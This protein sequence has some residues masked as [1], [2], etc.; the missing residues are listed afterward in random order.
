MMIDSDVTGSKVSRVFIQHCWV[1]L[2]SSDRIAAMCKTHLP[3]A[4]DAGSRVSSLVGI[5]VEPPGVEPSSR[6]MPL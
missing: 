1:E 4:A 5:N 3:T 2:D 6:V